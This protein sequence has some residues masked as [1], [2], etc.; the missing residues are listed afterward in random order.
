M[1]DQTIRLPAPKS[2]FL[3]GL[4]VQGNVI[5][6]LIMRELHTRYGR[7]NVG[8][9]WM[10]LEPMT[11]ATA[12]GML[13]LFQKGTAYGSDFQ[14]V[15]FALVGYCV[16]IILRS[17]VSRS[18]GVIEANAPLLYHRMVTVFDMVFS[19]TLLE[20]AGICVTLIILLGLTSAMGLAHLPA[21]PLALMAGF[22]LMVWFSFGLSAIVCAIT[23]D[24]R[25]AGRLVHPVLY[26][27]MPLSGA[28][29]T[30][31]W[32][33]VAFRAK[34]TL[35]PTVGIFELVRYGEFRAAEDTYFNPL[36]IIG[37]CAVLTYV[38]LICLKVVRRHI[39]L[40]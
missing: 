17:I 35:I 18:E 15:P 23:N 25:L 8:Y 40:N 20:A 6:A 5:G 36:Y 3:R 12:I 32:L 10:V 2:T 34:V 21:R 33:P 26:I 7:D 30:V 27:F 39:I 9:L 13:H 29:Y 24:N 4:S 31:R 19:R 38:G 28:F 14:P 16:Y 11:L 37:W 22:A 1:S